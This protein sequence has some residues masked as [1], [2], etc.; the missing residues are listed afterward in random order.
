M[1]A[2]CCRWFFFPQ[3]LLLFIFQTKIRIKFFPWQKKKKKKAYFNKNP[4]SLSSEMISYEKQGPP[5]V[6]ID[7][8]AIEESIFQLLDYKKKK[9]TSSVC[10]AQTPQQIKYELS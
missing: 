6:V 5:V 10:R 3:E 8:P 7:V 1:C 4:L 2:Q 9:S